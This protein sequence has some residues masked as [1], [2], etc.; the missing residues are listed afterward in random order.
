MLNSSLTNLYRYG[1]KSSDEKVEFD[2]ILDDVHQRLECCGLMGTGDYATFQIPIPPSCFNDQ[3][4]AF[5]SS[6]LVKFRFES[7]SKSQTFAICI[8]IMGVLVFI[9][10]LIDLVLLNEFIRDELVEQLI[11]KL[12]NFSQTIESKENSTHSTR[13]TQVQRFVIDYLL[14]NSSS[15]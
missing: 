2:R 7:I 10:V 1:R 8:Y 15:F 5:E 4:V 9:S 14:E 3:G 13:S 6:C 11:E 12:T